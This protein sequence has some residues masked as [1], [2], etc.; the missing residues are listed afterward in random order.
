MIIALAILAALAIAAIAVPSAIAG[1]IAA[2]VY[3]LFLDDTEG[4]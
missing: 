1:W 2:A 3:A 4:T